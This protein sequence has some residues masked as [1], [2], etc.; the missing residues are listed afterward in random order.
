M[1]TVLV[2]IKRAGL[3]GRC[4]FTRKARLEMDIDGLEE[5]DVIESIVA[6]ERVYKMLRSTSPLRGPLRERLY[7]ILGK[8]LHGTPIYTKGKLIHE[9]GADKFY[10]LVSAKRA[11]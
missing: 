5:S 10:V 11:L 1:D 2:R 8:S 4:V 3:W 6:A 9:S 7:V